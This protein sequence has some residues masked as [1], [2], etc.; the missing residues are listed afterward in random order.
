MGLAQVQLGRGDDTGAIASLKQAS[1]RVQDPAEKSSI[2]V[3]TAVAELAIGDTLN[4]CRALSTAD[5]SASH[6]TL[7]RPDVES[8]APH[9]AGAQPVSSVGG[10]V[11]GVPEDSATTSAA[12]LK[13]DS[14]A[15][16]TTRP[17]SHPGQD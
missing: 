8:V 17:P 10:N 14:A 11:T 7:L 5:S 16:R 12:H 1:T 15:K 6:N 3:Y 9:C 13:A 2:A 4:A